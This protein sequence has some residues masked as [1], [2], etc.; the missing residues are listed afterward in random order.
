MMVINHY[1]IIL[2][3]LKKKINKIFVTS[4]KADVKTVV[5]VLKTVYYNCN[6]RLC[7]S[8]ESTDGLKKG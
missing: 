8:L 2:I 7:N 6:V 1:T 3:E 4:K 5:K